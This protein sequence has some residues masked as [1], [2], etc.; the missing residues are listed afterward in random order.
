MTQRVLVTGASGFVGTAVLEQLIASHFDVTALV[1]HGDLKPGMESVRVV[2]GDLFTDSTLEKAV[3]GADAVIHLVGIIKEV[4]RRGITFDRIHVHGA[5]NVLDAA[6]RAGITR[7]IHM[8][9]LGA[10]A[11]APSD[12][13]RTKFMAEH[14]LRKS[15]MDW[16]IFQPSL[17]HGPDGEFTRMEAAWA[18]G[19]KP[20]FLFMPYFGGGLLGLRKAAH[21]QPVYV[22][23]VARA[24]VEAIDNPKSNHQTLPLCGSQILTWPQMHHIAAEL[25][26]GKRKAAIPVPA[27][28]ARILAS[29]APANWLPF[30]KDQVLMSQS[31]NTADMDGFAE[32]FG[33]EPRPFDVTLSEYAHQL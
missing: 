14:R 1:H 17:I 13:H 28:C 6:Q 4:P 8:S 12:Y 32:A 33:W 5:K 15:A 16:T 25:F 21:V 23:E 30:T 7:M 11:E 3:E 27:W 9:A 31:D 22:K 10:A 26:A 29:V 19:K 18:R 2:R 20:P 24:F